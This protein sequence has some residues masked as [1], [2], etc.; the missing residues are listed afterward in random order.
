MA[1][2]GLKDEARDSLHILVPKH[3]ELWVCAHRAAGMYDV[4]ESIG[5]GRW[6]V[7]M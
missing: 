5:F 3:F 7:S 1:D 6:K 2:D 4:L